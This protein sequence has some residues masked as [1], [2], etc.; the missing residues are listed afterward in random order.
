VSTA[1]KPTARELLERLHE[2]TLK[3][4]SAAPDLYAEDAVHE[5]PFSPAGAPTK[6]EGR[7]TLRQ[8]MAA[9]GS[10]PVE[11]QEFADRVV[12]ET[13]DPEVVIAEYNI[14]GKVVATGESFSFPNLM[15]LQARDGEIVKTRGY[16]NPSQLAELIKAS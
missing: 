11:Y 7:D 10:S 8:M 13:T 5:I 9:Q 12:Y 1:D 15:I 16:F 2:L 6:I 4:E 3:D 14:I